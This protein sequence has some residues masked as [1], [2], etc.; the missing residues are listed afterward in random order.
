MI[1]LGRGPRTGLAFVG[2][3]I[4]MDRRGNADVQVEYRG[5]KRFDVRSAGGAT[6]AR[7]GDDIEILDPDGGSHTLILQANDRR[8][9]QASPVVD[10]DWGSSAVPDQPGSTTACQRRLGLNGR[11]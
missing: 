8:P 1:P 6:A 2:N 9:V 5:S 11:F 10:D 3:E 7:V 4:Q